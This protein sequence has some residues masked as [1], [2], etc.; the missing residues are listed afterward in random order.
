VAHI[1]HRI[2]I[3]YLGQIVELADSLELCEKPLHPYTQ[4]LNACSIELP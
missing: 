4:A 3:M 1:S 2:A